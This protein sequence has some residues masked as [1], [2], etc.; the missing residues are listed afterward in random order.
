MRML[1]AGS[2]DPVTCGHM[3][4]IERTARLCDEL[5]VAVM[6]NP[7]KRGAFAVEQRVSLLE[8]ACAHISNVRVIAHG[9]LLV[10]CAR[11]QGAGCV[12]RGVRP[13]GD[14]ESEYQ[15]AQVNRMLGG[16]E[17]LMM[18][19]TESLASVSS[20]I[21]RQ[22]AAFGGEIDK[23]VPACI[24]EEICEALAKQRG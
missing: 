4:I 8:N 3:D 22:I 6:H 11:E 13:L 19:T 9:G 1:Y 12:V 7:D 14:F 24:A 23:L 18:P 2:F 17:T 21:V 10:D 15:M 16:V 20:S 5:V